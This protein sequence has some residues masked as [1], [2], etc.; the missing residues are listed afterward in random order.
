VIVIS[1]VIAH[2]GLANIVLAFLI[3]S[4][5]LVDIAINSLD[6]S[7]TSTLGR[8]IRRVALYAGGTAA[9]SKSRS[10]GWSDLAA[11]LGRNWTERFGRRGVSGVTGR[12]AGVR[13]VRVDVILVV[14]KRVLGLLASGAAL[15]EREAGFGTVV[16]TFLLALAVFSFGPFLEE[17][18]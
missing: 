2:L 11:T 15:V 10:A 5:G 1:L 6:P 14:R 7:V 16:P 17:R 18:G 13:G 12:A 9:L 8:S 3:V 4:N